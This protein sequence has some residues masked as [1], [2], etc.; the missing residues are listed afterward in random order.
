MQPLIMDL[1]LAD[2]S[3][4]SA[5]DSWLNTDVIR[6]KADQAQREEL[7]RRAKADYEAKKRAK[8]KEVEKIKSEFRNNFLIWRILC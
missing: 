3:T 7:I 4:H 6:G 5:V 8:E 1:G 2:W